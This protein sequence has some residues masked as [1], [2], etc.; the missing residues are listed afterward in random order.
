MRL[1]LDPST[2][3]GLLL[4]RVPSN[5]PAHTSLGSSHP[6]WALSAWSIPRHPSLYLLQ[7]QLSHHGTL[8]VDS[9]K[10]PQMLP[11]PLQL[12]CQGTLCTESPGTIPSHAHFSFTYP[13][14]ETSCM[15]H[16]RTLQACTLLSSIHFPQGT[17]CAEN[18]GTHQYTHF[19]SS[20]PVQL[21]SW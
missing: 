18:L 19:N 5:T 16:P 1:P 15:E 7:P 13:A 11:F 2:A 6:E 21:P 9:P 10:I 8:S 14:R 12:F 17:L 20:C 4:C 3:S